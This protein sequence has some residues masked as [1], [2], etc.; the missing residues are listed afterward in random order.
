[1]SPQEIGNTKPVNRIL[2]GPEF[3][4][5]IPYEIGANATITDTL[6][7]RLVI[8]DTIEGDVKEAGAK[9]ANVI[10]VLEVVSGMKETDAY[11]VGDP[12]VVISQPGARVVLDISSGSSAVV[13]GDQLMAAQGGRVEKVSSGDV[14]AT[15]LEKVTPAAGSDTR[16][17][18]RLAPGGAS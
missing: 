11:V 16:I 7:G 13:D 6:P 14:V 8:H 15:A 3:V 17:L 4:D 18:C 12:C 1:M 9:A 2:Q 10:G 5:L